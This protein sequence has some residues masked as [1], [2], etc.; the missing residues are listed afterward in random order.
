MPDWR[1]E[2]LSDG[3]TAVAATIIAGMVRVPK[4][5]L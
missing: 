4:E 5:I 2:S 3:H 1:P